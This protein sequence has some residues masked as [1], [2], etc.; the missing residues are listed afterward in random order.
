MKK[1][2]EFKALKEEAKLKNDERSDE[3][4]ISQGWGI[5]KERM[6]K[7]YIGIQ[8]VGLD[9]KVKSVTVEEKLKDT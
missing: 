6:K 8:D 2:N 9:E 5:R 7:W 4:R 3:D 1:R